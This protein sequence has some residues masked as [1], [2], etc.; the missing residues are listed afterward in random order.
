MQ[1]R[2]TVFQLMQWKHAI[3]LEAKGMKVARRSVNAHARRFLRLPGNGKRDQTLQVL[4]NVLDAAKGAGFGLVDF[5]DSN[6][7]GSIT[8]TPKEEIN[9]VE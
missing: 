8:I 3:R 5:V 6:E 9:N 1:T 4:E 7:D 2:S